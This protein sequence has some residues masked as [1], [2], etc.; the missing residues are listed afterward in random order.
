[1]PRSFYVYLEENYMIA[2]YARVSTA[3]QAKEGY[4]IDE[5][6]ERL[7]KYCEAQ[8]RTDYAVYVDAGM[9]G[10]NMNRAGLQEVIADAKAGKLDKVLVYKLDRLSR[11]QKNT[12]WLIEDAFMAHGVDFESMTERFDTGTSFGRAMV[13]ILAV[14]AQLERE[15]IK[16]RMT[17]GKQGRAK[18][19]KYYC[20]GKKPIGYDI[21]D[22]MLYVNEYEAM[23]IREA[24]KR[25]AE[26]QSL[27][28][29]TSAF[30]ELGYETKHGRWTNSTLY[31]VLGNPLYKGIIQNGTESYKG[32]HEPIV[33]DALFDAVQTSKS[34]YGSR[35]ARNEISASM[36]LGGR[37]WCK[38]CGARYNGWGY[39]RNGKAYRYYVC[40]SKRGNATMIKDANCKN[41]IYRAADLEGIIFDEIKKIEL[42]KD[43]IIQLADGNDN[44]K[45]IR[46]QEIAI[47]K[48]LEKIKSQK[49]R[50]IDLYSL[51]DIDKEAVAERISVLN[52]R[53]MTLRAQLQG[54]DD[55][56]PK[57]TP[58]QARQLVLGFSDMLERG[59]HD[60]IQQIIN[61]LIDRIEID[62][63]DVYIYWNFE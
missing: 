48:E 19:G 46:A 24:Y 20:S 28:A 31:H 41:K 50:L 55:K 57:M 2:I 53:E 13:G 6:V 25:Y 49:N 3:E 43:Y 51:G 10:A 12:L 34:R 52:Q 32:I 9:T 54:L 58:K 35:V 8:G 17:L 16:E 29:I 42:D 22:K 37:I 14:F 26:G 47:N 4:S 7:K 62:G 63:D 1:M 5:Q 30:A 44:E 23:Q 33:D 61:V 40:Y 56:K 36:Y 15:Q 27:N 39:K 38:Q 11:S 59:I 45:E 18:S 60:E 21:K